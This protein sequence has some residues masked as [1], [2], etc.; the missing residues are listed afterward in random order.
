M[1]RH[2]HTK[3]ANWF[4]LSF[5]LHIGIVVLIVIFWKVTPSHEEESFEDSRP[6]LISCTLLDRAITAETRSK[7]PPAFPA[8]PRV[9]P[10]PPSS[11]KTPGNPGTGPRAAGDFRRVNNEN[12]AA[13][14]IKAVPN[15]SLRVSEGGDS[16]SFPGAS[17]SAPVVEE[18]YSENTVSFQSASQVK[19]Q[20]SSPLKAP[21]SQRP[22][23]SEPVLLSKSEAAYPLIARQNEWDGTAMVE[24]SVSS[25]GTPDECRIL[26]TSGHPILDQAALEAARKT[27]YRPAY[28]EGRPVAC[29]VSLTYS[30][31]FNFR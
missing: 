9:Q 20:E 19:P 13:S 17:T 27:K 2:E 28:Q 1:G 5:L 6:L 11:R 12:K 30:F 3:W 18:I 7:A 21:A 8:A 10:L 16:S 4:L 22:L 23:F 29:L 25:E 26:S 14:S 15:I 24:I 31:N